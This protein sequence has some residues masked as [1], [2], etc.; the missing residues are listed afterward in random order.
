MMKQSQGQ[1]PTF[2]EKSSNFF[3]MVGAGA[4]TF[5]ATPFLYRSSVDWVVR[6]AFENYGAVGHALPPLWFV[7]VA[8]STFGLVNLVGKLAVS[9]GVARFFRQLLS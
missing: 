7:F 9:G 6:F 3:T 4:V 2:L 1:N 5:F 8:G